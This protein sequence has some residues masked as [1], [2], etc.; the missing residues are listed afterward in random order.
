MFLRFTS[1]GALEKRLWQHWRPGNV[2]A[3]AQ[4]SQDCI[5]GA[6]PDACGRTGSRNKL[7]L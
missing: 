5:S 6:T 2:D 1:F 7:S 4:T 3:C